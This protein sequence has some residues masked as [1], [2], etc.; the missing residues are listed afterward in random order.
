MHASVPPDSSPVA[1]PGL[2]AQLKAALFYQ[3][4]ETERDAFAREATFTN[5]PRVGIFAIGVAIVNLV[6]GIFPDILAWRLQGWWAQNP[7]YVWWFGMH[8]FL[9][10][11]PVV[12][13]PL[14]QYV[15]PA[16]PAGVTRRHH[17]LV[18]VYSWISVF[19]MMAISLIHQRFSGTISV[20]MLGLAAFA[21]GFYISARASFWLMLTSAVV[22]IL[23]L[24]LFQPTRI[25]VFSHS[26]IAID[27]VIFFWALSRVTYSL[28]AREFMQL[29]TIARQAEELAAT[30]RELAATNT[31]L[32]RA[33]EIKT[34]LIELAAHDLR[35]PLNTIALSAQTLSAE[36]PPGAVD[37]TL[38]NGI[39]ESAQRMSQLV[40]NLLIETEHEIH[41]IAL[42]R[43]NIDLP[44]L[45]AEVV[46]LYR[47]TA[48]AKQLT[49]HFTADDT[50]LRSPTAL[51]DEFRYRQIVENLVS[52]AVKYS[53]PGRRIWITVTRPAPGGHRLTVRD[54]GPGLVAGEQDRLFGKYQ[55]L[56]ARPTG[57]ETSTGLGLSIVKHL[58][59]LHDGTVRAESDGPGRGA[60]F[61]V[62]LP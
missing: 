15:R 33:G 19:G 9:V 36:L 59:T 40:E 6:L 44:R 61:I 24:P 47:A 8:V 50:A 20:Y 53:P 38:V 22:F 42:T 51:V 3:L 11:F 46:N 55:R 27:S 30:N 62:T 45:I 35:D 2:Y 34:E 37:P 31:A 57:G 56:S 18:L 23:A 17:A 41:E 48:S 29:K 25:I 16:Q 52:N 26:V 60:S 12:F 10:L 28:K 49:L 58:V 5:Y 1:R 39:T 13:V 21:T 54:E 4:P 43:R 7:A 32:A 14:M